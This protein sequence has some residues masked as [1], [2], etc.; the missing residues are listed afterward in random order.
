MTAMRALHLAACLLGALAALSGLRVRSMWFD[1]RHYFC[2]TEFVR[3]DAPA[4]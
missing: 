3:D 1:T 4:A 2:L